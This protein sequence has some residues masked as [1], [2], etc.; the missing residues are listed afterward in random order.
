MLSL[1]MRKVSLSFQALVYWFPHRVNFAC[2]Q[3]YHCLSAHVFVCGYQCVVTIDFD[4]FALSLIL[5][6]VILWYFL[7]WTLVLSDNEIIFIVQK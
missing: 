4:R 7:N 3:D 1:C 5:F 6:S 2:V